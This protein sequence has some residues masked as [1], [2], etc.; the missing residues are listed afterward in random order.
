MIVDRKTADL[1]FVKFQSMKVAGDAEIER[2]GS[3][4]GNARLHTTAKW[5]CQMLTEPPLLTLVEA[6]LQHRETQV[7]PIARTREAVGQHFD[8]LQSVAGRSDAMD[9]ICTNC[10]SDHVDGMAN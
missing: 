7:H 6:T 8:F 9:E 10:D 2:M 5:E 4:C 1:D 3:E